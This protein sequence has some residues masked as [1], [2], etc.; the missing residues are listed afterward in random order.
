[1]AK[2]TGSNNTPNITLPIT[3]VGTTS[4]TILR[5][6][7]LPIGYYMA[8]ITISIH[9]ATSANDTIAVSDSVSESYENPCRL[10]RPA[11][12]K[13]FN[14]SNGSLANCL[15]MINETNLPDPK[16]IYILDFLYGAIEWLRGP[17]NTYKDTV[18]LIVAAYGY[19]DPYDPNM[20]ADSTQDVGNNSIVAIAFA[21][22]CLSYPNHEK[23]PLYHECVKYLISTFVNNIEG[24]K[25]TLNARSAANFP[26]HAIDD[27]F[28]SFV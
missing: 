24:N 18:K 26:S 8:T 19:S 21:K 27:L 22:F 1:M 2:I 12:I 28:W 14:I 11:S 13:A 23:T 16:V 17:S 5:V 6:T 10:I 15:I 4:T 25:T 9:T 20:I 3:L 7:N